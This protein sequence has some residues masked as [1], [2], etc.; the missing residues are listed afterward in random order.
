MF[1]SC[2]NSGGIFYS[3]KM[4]YTWRVKDFRDGMSEITLYNNGFAFW[5]IETTRERAH[6][7]FVRALNS[8]FVGI[9]KWS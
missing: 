5:G 8:D 1:A 3:N 9:S 7:F 4:K 2:M 6:R